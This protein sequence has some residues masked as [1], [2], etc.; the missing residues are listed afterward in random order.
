KLSLVRVWSGTISEGMVLNG[1]RVAG[2]LRLVGA[3]QG[4]VPAA[5]AGEDVG[6]TRMEEIATGAVLTPS[7]KAAPLLQPERPQPVYGLAISSERRPAGVELTGA[8][9]KLIE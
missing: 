2:V 1:S 3:Q 6:L 7:G 9:G 5:Q 4:K 8:R